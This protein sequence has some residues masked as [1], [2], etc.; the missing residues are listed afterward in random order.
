MAHNGSPG[1]SSS[2]TRPN[3]LP[4]IASES[5][6]RAS[7]DTASQSLSIAS[8]YYDLTESQDTSNQSTE[9]SILNANR[10]TDSQLHHRSSDNPRGWT[11]QQLDR[12]SPTPHL[13]D[14]AFSLQPSPRM[15]ARSTLHIEPTRI[16]SHGR[17][18]SSATEGDVGIYQIMHHAADSDSSLNL[19]LARNTTPEITSSE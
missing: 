10:D 19:E 8:Y 3:L 4:P 14:D 6:N 5:D 18:V 16:G 15:P 13:L 17:V 1:E 2:R 7:Q 11:P 12:I 9:P